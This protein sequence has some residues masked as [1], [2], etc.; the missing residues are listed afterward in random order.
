MIEAPLAAHRRTGRNYRPATS[1]ESHES[2]Y[3]WGEERRLLPCR[4]G[5]LLEGPAEGA[6]RVGLTRR[7]PRMC[8]RLGAAPPESTRP[9]NT[10]H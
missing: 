6:E 2:S 10:S 9:L 3:Y 5:R 7:D 4:E 1:G 8:D